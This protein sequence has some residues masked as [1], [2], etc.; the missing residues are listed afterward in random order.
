M[1]GA[2]IKK[3]RLQRGMTQKN[4]A[5]QLFVSSQA[6]SRWENGEVEPSIGTIME[7]AKIF[8]VTADEILG[9]EPKETLDKNAKN[10]EKKQET[11]DQKKE[12]PPQI[13]TLCEKCNCPIYLSN[14]IVREDGMV[15]CTKCHKKHEENKRKDEERERYNTIRSAR[16]RRI[17]SLVFGSLAA[18]IFFIIVLNAGDFFD[19]TRQMIGASIIIPISMFTLVSCC[20]LNNNFVGYMVF[21]I[22]TWPIKM[23]GLIFGFDFDGCL[24]F[25]GMKILFAVLGIVFGILMFILALTIG[26]IVSIFVYPYA[27]IM[28]I[29]CPENTY[30]KLK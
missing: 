13:L 12:N 17:L 1:V 15:L 3:L 24:W 22:A 16:K 10:E 28:N 20:I 25:I 11:A 2:N 27:I 7:L 14:E 30:F 18:V 29:K 4:L 6:V 19:T 21:R 9:L 5:D 23:P 8:G 26:A